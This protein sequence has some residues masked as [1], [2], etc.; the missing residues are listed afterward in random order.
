MSFQYEEE[1]VQKLEPLKNFITKK[2]AS[3]YSTQRKPEKLITEG[4]YYLELRIYNAAEASK[5]S[6]GNRWRHA[7]FTYKSCMDTN[8]EI[9]QATNRLVA[10]AKEDFKGVKPTLYPA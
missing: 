2:I 6:P 10:A 4:D 8:S 9:W 3:G 5:I 1:V 7:L